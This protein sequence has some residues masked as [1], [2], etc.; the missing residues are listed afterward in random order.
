MTQRSAQLRAHQQNIERYQ[1]LLNSNLSEVEMKFVE[2][3]LSEE[4]FALAMLQFM[5]SS[6]EK[7]NNLPDALQ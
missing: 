5:S 3:R 7:K 4:R 1:R 2:L 6:N